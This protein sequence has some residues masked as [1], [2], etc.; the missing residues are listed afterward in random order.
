MK[1]NIFKSLFTSKSI[2]KSFSYEQRQTSFLWDGATNT[3]IGQP[4]ESSFAEELKKNVT[5]QTILNKSFNMVSEA[6]LK[7][8]V[9]KIGKDPT[10]KSKTAQLLLELLQNP[11]CEPAP[12]SWTE[13]LK[14]MFQQYTYYGV[15]GLVIKCNGDFESLDFQSL[16]PADT[17]YY[18]NIGSRNVYTVSFSNNTQ[19]GYSTS[20]EF[21]YRDGFYI[22]REG[23]NDLVLIK[24]GNFNYNTKQFESPLKNLEMA[25]KTQNMLMESRYAFLKNGSRPSGVV[26]VGTDKESLNIDKRTG[27]VYLDKSQEEIIQKAVADLQTQIKGTNNTGKVITA[28]AMKISFT[29]IS[30]P[31]NAKEDIELFNAIQ[32]MLYT[33]EGS[34]SGFKNETEYSNNAIEKQ[35]ELYAM[36]F[37]KV[38]NS[39]ITPLNQFLQKFLAEFEGGNIDRKDTYFKLEENDT[40]FYKRYIEERASLKYQN[41]EIGR[42]D[43]YNINSEYS[44]VWAGVE[45]PQDNKL[46]LEM[47]KGGGFVE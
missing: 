40:Q 32:T 20:R 22:A 41:N 10:S 12:T 27:Q 26:T 24:M 6:E 1:T 18:S 28:G 8:F 21:E 42:Q 36:V 25:I 33:Y 30:T 13:L 39:I 38:N 37:A 4:R 3:V 43:L 29:P 47:Q 23:E 5:V 31:M 17:V 2:K 15:V 45:K 16:I 14:F 34:E 35:K 7:L 44:E 46:L 9:D 19:S 11:N